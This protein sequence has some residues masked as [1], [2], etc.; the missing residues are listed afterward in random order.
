MS[1]AAKTHKA[2]IDHGGHAQGGPRCRRDKFIPSSAVSYTC[3][4]NI[5]HLSKLGMGFSPYPSVANAGITNY[6]P[7]HHQ[8]S[9]K[10]GHGSH[11]SAQ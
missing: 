9:I 3:T 2:N 6:F 7:I 10:L 8:S 5:K 11:K 1:V 4:Q